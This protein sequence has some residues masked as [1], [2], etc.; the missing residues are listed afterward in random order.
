MSDTLIKNAK[1]KL[2]LPMAKLADETPCF[3][4]LWED[5]S[6]VC[7]ELK[8]QLRDDCEDLFKKIAQHAQLA[9]TT[10]LKPV[11]HE[12]AEY[13]PVGRTIDNLVR[14]FVHYLKYPK[15]LPINWSYHKMKKKEY[16][17][18][19]L[20][21]TASYHAVFVDYTMVC[22]FWTNAAAFGIL[23]CVPELA[24]EFKNIGFQVGQIPEKN[25]P[26]SKPCTHRI[27]IL[28]E[29]DAEKAASTLVSHYK[30]EDSKTT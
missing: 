7:P 28:K 8:C 15:E 25:M 26:K 14:L 29:E 23:D 24:I 12:R 9:S 11:K 5:E 2:T 4:I 19:C 27:Y 16:P 17:R 30:C 1:Q 6:G 10:E 18:Y 13:T 20:V 3:G 22:R 21:K